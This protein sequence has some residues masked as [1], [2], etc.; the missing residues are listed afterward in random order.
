MKFNDDA[1][2]D[3]DEKEAGKHLSQK[4]AHKFII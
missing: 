3:G 1:T 2:K 4:L